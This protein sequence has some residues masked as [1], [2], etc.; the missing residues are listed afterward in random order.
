MQLQIH[1]GTLGR[2]DALES[3][4][5]QAFEHSLRHVE[6]ELTRV[7]VFLHDDNA[8]KGGSDDKRVVAEAHPRGSGPISVEDTG[9]D[10]YQLVRATAKKLE[11]SCRQFVEKRRGR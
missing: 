6:G 10:M 4:V 11:R 8:D 2:T 9:N 1:Y 5:R 3:E 7:D